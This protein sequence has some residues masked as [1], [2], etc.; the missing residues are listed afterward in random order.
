MHTMCINTK[1][2]D[3]NTPGTVKTAV[4]KYHNLIGNVFFYQCLKDI[5]RSFSAGIYFLTIGYFLY[6]QT[7]SIYMDTFNNAHTIKQRINKI[8]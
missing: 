1:S 7:L 4:Q 6:T 5:E 3:I 8:H 2:H